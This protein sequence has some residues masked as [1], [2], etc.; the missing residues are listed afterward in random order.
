AWN[1]TLADLR[2]AMPEAGV[3]LKDTRRSNDSLYY[4]VTAEVKGRPLAMTIAVL[5]DP[6]SDSTAT[7]WEL[8]DR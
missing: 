1:T 2:A 4:A 5:A 8:R 7:L 6:R 3:T